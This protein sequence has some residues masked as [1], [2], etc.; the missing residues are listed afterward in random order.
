MLR[1][2]A[3]R[4]ALAEIDEGGAPVGQADQHEAAAADVAREGMRHRQR[5][6]HRDRG[7]DG[8]A[9]GLQNLQPGF[10]GVAFAR[11]H[12]AVPRAHRLRGPQRYGDR[13][14]QQS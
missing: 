1:E 7:I 12:H 2:A 8:V 13:D 11:D 14:Q 10:G 5:E 3:P 6:S 9:A 4:R